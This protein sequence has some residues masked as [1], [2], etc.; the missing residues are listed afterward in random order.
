MEKLGR[1]NETSTDDKTKKTH[2]I[3]LIVSKVDRTAS[4]LWIMEFRAKL[5]NLLFAVEFA[6]H[7]K[8]LVYWTKVM[9]NYQTLGW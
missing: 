3:F 6:I 5:Q 8:F 9:L 7:C 2:S 4:F 1:L